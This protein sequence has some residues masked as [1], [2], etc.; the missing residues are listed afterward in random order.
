MIKKNCD[1]TID[2]LQNRKIKMKIK[3][4]KLKFCKKIS[5]LNC[6]LKMK[7]WWEQMKKKKNFFWILCCFWVP[8]HNGIFEVCQKTKYVHWPFIKLVE[9]ENKEGRT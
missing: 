1:T 4:G 7:L 5:L 6:K 8:I 2:G 9:G 3:I